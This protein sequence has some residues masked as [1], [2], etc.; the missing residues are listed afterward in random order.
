LFHG[1][2]ATAAGLLY[3]AGI[4]LLDLENPTRVLARSDEWVLGPEAI[5]E[6]T[7][8]VPGVVFPTGWI[9]D[10]EGGVR[11]YYG[12]ADTCVAV[13]SARIDDLVGFVHSH[14]I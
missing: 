8:D 12:A 14:G 3:R 4:A 13:A 2:K 6:R 1:V 11:M 5:Y 7:G 9:A 10:G